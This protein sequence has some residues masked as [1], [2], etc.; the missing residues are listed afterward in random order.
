M[1]KSSKLGKKLPEMDGDFQVEVI[2]NITKKRVIGEFSCKIMNRKER[3]LVA[4]HRA[5]LNGEMA[6]QLD[7]A[8]LR[9]H[10]MISY[11]RYALTDYPKWWKEADLGYELYDENIVKEVYDKVLEFEEEWIKEVWGEEAVNKL[12]TED[13]EEDEQET[14]E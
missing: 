13:E 6:S 1:S 5:F 2:G 14:G 10:M 11:L 4:K 9:F 12:K 3:A 7:I 8:T